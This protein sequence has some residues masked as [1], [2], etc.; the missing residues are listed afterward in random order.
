MCSGQGF[1]LVVRGRVGWQWFWLAMEACLSA[2]P[3]T[4]AVGWFL[5]IVLAALIRDDVAQTLEIHFSNAATGN[6]FKLVAP[7]DFG[8]F[9]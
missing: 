1:A 5:A 9:F 8:G 7:Q 4:L 3:L 6:K 2:L